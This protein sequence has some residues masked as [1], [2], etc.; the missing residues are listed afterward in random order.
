MCI[1]GNLKSPESLATS[2]KTTIPLSNFQKKLMIRTATL[3]T[4]LLLILF[5]STETVAQLTSQKIDSLIENALVKFKV[6]AH[7]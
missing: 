3:L 2:S 1:A 6:A 7:L 5:V 4:S